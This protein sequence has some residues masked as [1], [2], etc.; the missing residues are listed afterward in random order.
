[1]YKLAAMVGLFSMA[2]ADPSFF[3]VPADMPAAVELGRTGT[4]MTGSNLKQH[5]SNYG[6]NN[7]GGAPHPLVVTEG[8]DGDMSM[9]QMAMARHGGKADMT[10]INDALGQINSQVSA[11]EIQQFRICLKRYAKKE[12]DEEKHTQFQEI[13]QWLATDWPKI[14]Q[15]LCRDKYTCWK[16][17]IK[18][19]SHY[20]LPHSWRLTKKCLKNVILVDQ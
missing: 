12:S 16:H 1:M 13:K 3:S 19:Q 9:E 11:I 10:N 2:I 6:L 4:G 14:G 17:Y 15:F 7:L 5:G 8:A 20:V 18:S